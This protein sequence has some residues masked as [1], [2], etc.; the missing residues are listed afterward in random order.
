MPSGERMVPEPEPWASRPWREPRT[1]TCTTDGEN[2]LDHADHGAGIGVEQLL[3]LAAAGAVGSVGNE[4]RVAVAISAPQL[5]VALLPKL[6]LA[7]LGF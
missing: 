4:R 1:C 6:A 2:G 5:H 3:V 7:L